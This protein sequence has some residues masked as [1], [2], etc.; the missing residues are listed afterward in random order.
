M[1]IAGKRWWSS[2]LVEQVKEGERAGVL[3]CL[4]GRGQ[5]STEVGVWALPARESRG[6]AAQLPKPGIALVPGSPKRAMACPLCPATLYLATEAE[7]SPFSSLSSPNEGAWGLHFQ[8]LL[9]QGR[10]RRKKGPN[11]KSGH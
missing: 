6:R 10:P 5:C 9:P 1:S 4:Q 11:P 7:G 2:Q 8:H 3:V